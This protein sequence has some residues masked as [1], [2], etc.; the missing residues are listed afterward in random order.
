MKLGFTTFLNVYGDMLDL[1]YLEHPQLLSQSVQPNLQKSQI[2]T[3]GCRSL[4]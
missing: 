4:P 1:K 2:D 3:Y